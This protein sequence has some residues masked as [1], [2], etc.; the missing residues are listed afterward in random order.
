M[1][2]RILSVAL[3]LGLLGV[4]APA[5]AIEVL[6]VELQFD[7]LAGV[8]LNTCVSNGQYDCGDVGPNVGFLIAP[9]AR[10]LDYFGL[11][12]D[13]TFGWLSPDANAMSSAGPV[14]DAS[15]ST[16]QVMPVFRGFYSYNVFGLAEIEFY[17]GLGAG[18]SRMKA[19]YEIKAAGMSFDSEGSWRTFFAPKFNAG[20]IYRVT[21]QI[22]VGLNIDFV[23]NIDGT[24][25]HCS[26]ENG[27]G[28]CHDV[29]DDFEQSEFMQ[30][31]ILG[32]YLF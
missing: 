20:G 9:G 26:E 11:Y 2:K 23:V 15:V 21:E 19:S 5:S 16:I 1:K 8:G 10:F 7:A 32:S 17:G 28:S 29:P 25:R 14:G 31:L 22:G 3:V 13:I 30:I 24:G 27:D 12:L 18:W 6:G 4:A